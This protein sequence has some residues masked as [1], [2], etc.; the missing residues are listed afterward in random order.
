MGMSNK[1]FGELLILLIFVVVY[2]MLIVTYVRPFY[3]A[4]VSFIALI[5][6]NI[7]I[8]LYLSYKSEKK[9]K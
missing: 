1:Q 7:F 4:M 9:V 3:E 6:P 5:V 2:P 8:I